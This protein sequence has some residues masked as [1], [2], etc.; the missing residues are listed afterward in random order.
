MKNIKSLLVT[1]AVLAAFVLPNALFTTN[2]ITPGRD[3]RGN[4]LTSLPPSS[5]DGGYD[6]RWHTPSHFFVYPITD[7]MYYTSY[8]DFDATI[9]PYGHWANVTSSNSSAGPTRLTIVN[10]SYGG[11]RHRAL[12]LDWGQ[13]VEGWEAGKCYEGVNYTFPVPIP[14]NDSMSPW[15]FEFDWSV[16]NTWGNPAII[17]VQHW[18]KIWN[19]SNVWPYELDLAGQRTQRLLTYVDSSNV[20]VTDKIKLGGVEVDNIVEVNHWYRYRFTIYNT[21]HFGLSV[22]NYTSTGRGAWVVYDPMTWTNDWI[23]RTNHDVTRVVFHRQSGNWMVPSQFGASPEYYIS[24][25]T[26]TGMPA[27]HDAPIVITSDADWVVYADDG[28]GSATNPWIVENYDIDC[29]G[30]GTGISISG[31]T[32]HAIFRNIYINNTGS[33]GTD[34]GIA[35]T[36][37]INIEFQ[38][39]TIENSPNIGIGVIA[40]GHCTFSDLG[41]PDTNG[42]AL[43]VES[44]WDI[45]IGDAVLGGS[46]AVPY[47]WLST[48]MTGNGSTSIVFDNITFGSF[49]RTLIECD[50]SDVLLNASTIVANGVGLLLNCPATGR[51]DVERCTIT[52]DTQLYN[53]SV[54]FDGNYWSNYFNVYPYAM[55]MNSSTDILDTPYQVAPGNNDTHPRYRASMWPRSDPVSVSFYNVLDGSLLAFN[56]FNVMVDGIRQPTSTIISGHVLYNVVVEKDGVV[57]H[58]ALYNVNLTGGTLIIGIDLLTYVHFSFYST[59]DFFGLDFG[60]VKLYINGTRITTASPAVASKIVDIVVRDFANVVL[61]NATLNLS[62]SG[63]Y[64]DIGL[65]IAAIVVKNVYD[66]T[67]TFSLERNNVTITYTLPSDASMVL[68]LA[69]GNYTEIVRVGGVIVQNTTLSFSSG[70]PEGFSVII[71]YRATVHFAFFSSVDDAGLDFSIAKLYV[72]GTR[73]T[74]NVLIVYS[75][76]LHVRVTDA[77]GYVLYTNTSIDIDVHGVNI[78]IYL[79]YATIS[80]KNNYNYT[81][82]LYLFKGDGMKV[83]TLSGGAQMFPRLPLGSYSY[84]VYAASNG[85]LVFSSTVDFVAGHPEGYVISF[86]F[87]TVTIPTIPEYTF[88]WFDTLISIGVFVVIAIVGMVIFNMR[89]YKRINERVKAQLSSKRGIRI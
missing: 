19:S 84:E 31:T 69:T 17:D 42:V 67:A 47:A 18:L 72:N 61:Y 68:R 14:I 81:V 58:D 87:A 86:G 70:H 12:Y 32:N 71:G 56:L 45:V 39:C 64:L 36:N 62:I 57:Y 22:A 29:G 8:N 55:L 15:N 24:N 76:Y 16:P 88:T 3:M 53:G 59:I 4:V 25:I 43:Y 6:F 74:S 33:G 46:S 48:A 66:T 5:A 44:S 52:N 1:V 73:V 10:A 37:A 28:D 26:Y 30:A 89:Y 35:I 79:P 49:Y 51:I 65:P 82:V 75:R 2:G 85:S 27:R 77:A 50:D 60:L 23:G 63:V 20:S 21:T 11:A 83:Y 54:F 80:I 40:A 78:D 34:C 9:D 13:K 7:P 38:H 41:I